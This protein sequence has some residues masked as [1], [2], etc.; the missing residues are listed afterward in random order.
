[1]QAEKEQ[2]FNV[3]RAVLAMAG[4]AMALIGW[5]GNV[6]PNNGATVMYEKVMIQ[7]TGDLSVVEPFRTSVKAGIDYHPYL[8]REDGVVFS[9]K[10]TDGGLEDITENALGQS[11]IASP[12]VAGDLL[13]FR[14][15]RH[16]LAF[17]E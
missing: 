9:A 6:Y 14:G 16:L 10:V 3:D 1:M 15:D 4:N 7:E 17:G 13:L 8:P 5:A 2:S 11:M 12:V